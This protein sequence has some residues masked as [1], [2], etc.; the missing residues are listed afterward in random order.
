MESPKV[1]VIT[2]RSKGL[3]SFLNPAALV[4]EL[5]HQRSI[6][7]RFT[8][9]EILS[10]YKG[11][12]LGL[13]WTLIT[14]LLMLTVYTFV[15]TVVLRVRWGQQVQSRAGFAL[16]MFCG[17]IVFNIISECLNRASSLVAQNI[18]YVKRIVFP[19]Q[20]FPVS[21]VLS[22]LILA[23]IGTCVFLAALGL[24]VGTVHWTAVLFPLILV[25]VALLGLGLAW[26]LAS[27]GVYL[28]DINHVMAVVTQILF[29]AT[30]IFYPLSAVPQPYRSVMQI[31]PLAVLVESSRRAL[32]WGRQPNW[33]ALGGVTLLCVV[34]AQLGYA[35]FM[36]TKRGFADVL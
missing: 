20:A 34:A 5:W 26:F 2:P 12:R 23:L 18:I 4:R 8:V 10:R 19:L 16:S 22:A 27:L 9:R 28:R 17:L 6:I 3:I 13:V 31:N 33:L 11:S 29:F 35:W 15:F 24:L 1:T 25:P 36:K 7:K 32:L 14:P 21:L 30:P